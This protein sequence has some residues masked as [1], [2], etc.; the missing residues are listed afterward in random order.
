MKKLF[1][2]SGLGA[3]E[4]VF[5]FLDLSDCTIHHIQW[6][7]PVPRESMA[8]YAQRILPQI[9]DPNPNGGFIRRDG[10]CGDCE[11]NSG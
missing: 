10:R 7:K 3:D 9:T 8:D 6:I 2:L 1:L 4:R 5:D 11:V